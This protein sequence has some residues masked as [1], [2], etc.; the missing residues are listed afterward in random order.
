MLKVSNVNI[1]KKTISDSKELTGIFHLMKKNGISNPRS[2]LPS[3][4]WHKVSFHLKNTYTGFA[5][6]IRRVLIEEI[7]VKCMTLQEK[8]LITDD[9]FILSDIVLKNINLVPID[10]IVGLN[11][12]AD[13]TIFIDKY[14]NTNNVINVKASDIKIIS[15]SNIKSSKELSIKQLI[16]DSNITIFTLRPGKN[17]KILNITLEE[18]YAKDDASKFSLLDNVSYDILDMIP[19]DIFK[20]TG[21]RSIEYDPKEFSLSFTTCGNIT[22]TMVVDKLYKTLFTKLTTTKDLLLEYKKNGITEKII[23]KFELSVLEDVY[24]YKFIG[25]YVTLTNM[26]AQRCYL[27]DPTILFCSPAIDRYDNEVAI[28]RLK[29]PDTHKLLVSAIDACLDDLKILHNEL[30]KK[31]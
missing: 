23:D 22:P 13:K 1:D 31:N 6:A 25:E 10:Q 29:H 19:Y 3:T 11:D 14:N 4:S 15:K 30:T 7:L 9:E 18:G 26:L 20:H 17:V 5:N 16:P 12:Y 2:L 28:I 24:T 8:D 27:L 21:T